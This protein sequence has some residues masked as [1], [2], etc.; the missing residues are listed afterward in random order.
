MKILFT[1]ASGFLG[2]YAAPRLAR[3]HEV[4]GTYI[5][6]GVPLEGVRLERLD[7]EDGPAC[8][9]LL[10]REN[11]D[12]VVHAAALSRP[13]DCEADPARAERVNLDALDALCG[14]GAKLVFYSTDLVFDGKAPPYREGDPPSPTNVYSRL[15]AR[16]ERTVLDR[17][18]PGLVL[19]L[20]LGYGWKPLGHPMFCDDL[21]R[22]LRGG[23]SMTLFS[24]QFRSALYMKDAAEILARLVARPQWPERG[25]LLH[26]G[27]PETLSRA[28]F[29]RAF[30]R[31]VGLDETLIEEE[32]MAEAGVTAAADCTLNSERLYERVGFR[33][34]GIEAGVADMA[35]ENPYK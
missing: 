14:F 33:P 6:N 22:R 23:E 1:G 26:C 12:C 11:P 17:R 28:R 24:D 32:T 30:C 13:A 25:E 31:A 15:K 5:V 2:R 3:E 20:G 10:E 19:R 29:G 18:A 4:V 7:L 16:A 8:R 9:R 34:R 21:Y 27:G 35:R